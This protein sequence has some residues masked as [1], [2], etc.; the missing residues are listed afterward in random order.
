[1]KTI[2]I[3]DIKKN[4]E[5]LLELLTDYCPKVEVI[6]EAE[7]ATSAYAII[8]EKQPD[9]LLLDVEMP[10]GTGFDLL[11]KFDDVSFEV[12]FVTAHDRYALKAI[13]FCALDYILK[14]VDVKE[15]I[16]AIHRATEKLKERNF[17]A[18]FSHLVQNMKNKNIRQHKI[19]I[20]IQEG[21]IFIEVNDILRCEADGSYTQVML[22]SGKN[23]YATRKIKV[24]ED[25]L[26]DYHFFRV[27]RSYLIN[28]NYIEKYHKGEG[29]YV[30]MSDGTT[31]DVSR[32][33]KDDF[34][35]RLNAV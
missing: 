7:D 4:R 28:M 34:L 21:F 20:P 24:F 22:K 16:Q 13:K 30:V 1:M 35:E 6:G 5:V 15:F 29:G 10:D 2:I 8:K 32:R 23:I 11:D 26:S 12:V 25:L 3:D 9:L 27:H 17:S 31:V 33:K 18:N 19:A 14:P